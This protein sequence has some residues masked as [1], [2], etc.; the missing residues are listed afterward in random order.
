MMRYLLD[1]EREG[2][3]T[4]LKKMQSS[5]SSIA[6]GIGGFTRPRYLFIAYRYVV[7]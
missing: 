1:I 5:M 2:L 4:G 7:A 3:R 6:G